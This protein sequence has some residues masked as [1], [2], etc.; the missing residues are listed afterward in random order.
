MA[1]L[2]KE[3]KNFLE[4]GE[5]PNLAVLTFFPSKE[6]IESNCKCRT[7]ITYDFWRAIYDQASHQALSGGEIIAVNHSA[8]VRYR[9]A[10]GEILRTVVGH[11]DPLRFNLAGCSA[12]LLYIAPIP[13]ESG[14]GDDPELELFF[15]SRS[16][17]RGCAQEV[18]EAVMSRLGVYLFRLHLR[19]DA[20]FV[21][22]ESFPV[23]FPYSKSGPPPS[24]SEYRAAHQAT[25]YVSSKSLR[26]WETGTNSNK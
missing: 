8:V 6:A 25:C 3:A 14:R 13:F 10:S 5:Q 11:S 22:D 23:I 19:A 4:S 1:S 17:S 24:E 7:D 21:E 12:N 9:S 15:Q 26:C 18:A 16:P 2:E 20:W